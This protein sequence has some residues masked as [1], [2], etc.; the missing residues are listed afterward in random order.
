MRKKKNGNTNFIGRRKM[1]DDEGNIRAEQASRYWLYT[2]V[3]QN[4]LRAS[5][6]FGLRTCTFSAIEHYY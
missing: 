4:L 5:F 1:G 2:E 6:V 3:I